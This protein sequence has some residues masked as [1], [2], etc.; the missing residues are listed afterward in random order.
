MGF[1]CKGWEIVRMLIFF[2]L[3]N[4]KWSWHKRDVFCF[5]LMIP[6]LYEIEE[7]DKKGIY[8]QVKFPFPLANRDVSFNRSQSVIQ[9][10]L[11]GFTLTFLNRVEVHICTRD[12]WAECG[13]GA[14]VG[15]PGSQWTVLDGSQAERS[16]A[17]RRL[18]PESG[19]YFWWQQGHERLSILLTI[20]C[21]YSSTHI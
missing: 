4:I 7:G 2:R 8:W 6:D 20:V 19:H 1:I 10:D 18:Y 12:A 14:S 21:A 16:R 15:R 5:V 13:R 11:L 17:C 3:M 9:N